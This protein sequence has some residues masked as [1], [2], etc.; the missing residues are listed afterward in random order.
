MPLVPFLPAAPVFPV[1]PVFPRLSWPFL[2]SLASRDPF[3][4]SV[5]V[6]ELFLICLPVMIVAA[7]A[8]PPSTTKTAMVL[9]TFAYVSLDLRLDTLLLT[10]VDWT[11]AT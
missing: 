2:K 11:A 7:V 3:L 9:M 4:M 6:I 10:A 8:V 1:L 5:E